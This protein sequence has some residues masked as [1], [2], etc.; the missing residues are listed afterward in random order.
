MVGASH[1]DQQD[2]RR[3]NLSTLAPATK[4]ILQS[5]DGIILWTSDWFTEKKNSIQTQLYQLFYSL[6]IQD[7]Y[8]DG[9]RWCIPTMSSPMLPTLA[10]QW[11]HQLRRPHASWRHPNPSF[12]NAASPAKLCKIGNKKLKQSRKYIRITRTNRKTLNQ[13]KTNVAGFFFLLFLFLLWL[14]VVALVVVLIV[15][16]ALVVAFPAQ[17][18]CSHVI[19]RMY[20]SVSVPSLLAVYPWTI[21]MQSMK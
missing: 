18:T 11:L 20:S 4:Q 12:A 5:S 10:L 7:Y 13:N 16:V 3:V 9:Y 1:E 6:F 21:Q 17:W 14:L 19:R 2:Q 15:G 8:I